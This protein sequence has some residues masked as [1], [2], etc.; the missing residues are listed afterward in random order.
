MSQKRRSLSRKPSH[1]HRISQAER[2][3]MAPFDHQ[4]EL[5]RRRDQLA[6][7]VSPDIT[8]E[9]IDSGHGAMTYRFTH[10]QF[11]PLGQL[12]V[13]PYRGGTAID[14]DVVEAD[15]ERDPHWDE[16]YLA[17]KTVVDL[18]IQALHGS[19]PMP[20]SPVPPVSEARQRRI[21]YLRFLH[22]E[23]S[24]ALF[25]LAKE[26]NAD[27]YERLLEVCAAAL[28]TAPPSDRVGIEQRLSELR[29]YWCDLQ[30]RPIVE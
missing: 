19:Q 3:V 13:K 11:G 12:H 21:L 24:V 17:L 9:P 7:Q 25:G 8:T 30:E 28:R 20:T 1:R 22:A 14:V 10:K 23:H 2:E 16:K 27:E 6:A 18:C 4:L 29:F 26:L 15:P 5:Q